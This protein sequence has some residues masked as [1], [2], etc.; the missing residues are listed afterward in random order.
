MHINRLVE[1]VLSEAAIE[2]LDTMAAHALALQSR[3]ITGVTG[4]PVEPDSWNDTVLL[5][6]EIFEA[7]ILVSTGDDWLGM[8]ILQTWG[9]KDGRL[10]WQFTPAFGQAIAAG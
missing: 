5:L 10:V 9:V 1:E 6:R 2:L 3:D 7:E 8:R 4:L